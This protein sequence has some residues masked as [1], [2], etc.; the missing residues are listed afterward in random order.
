M[1]AGRISHTG[2]AVIQWSSATKG[3]LTSYFSGATPT[4]TTVT[5]TLKVN[6]TENFS[7]SALLSGF[8]HAQPKDD[9]V[10][11]TVRFV[12]SGQMTTT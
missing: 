10:R 2:T 12:A 5:I 8:D 4:Q 7:F 11:V 9:Q 1:V 6:A 3:A